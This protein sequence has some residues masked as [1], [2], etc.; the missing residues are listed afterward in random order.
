MSEKIREYISS[1]CAGSSRNEVQPPDEVATAANADCTLYASSA[2]YFNASGGVLFKLS[3]SRFR[4]CSNA[5]RLK[6][7]DV[8]RI[9][10]STSAII[11]FTCSSGDSPRRRIPG[12]TV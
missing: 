6:I 9:L 11:C 2:Q 3:S 12:T 4:D 7:A 8:E 1:A 5:L 10:S